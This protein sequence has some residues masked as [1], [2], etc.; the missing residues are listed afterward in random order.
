M[1][2]IRRNLNSEDGALLTESKWGKV[3]RLSACNALIRSVPDL[4]G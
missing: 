1:S 3:W 2:V 4:Q